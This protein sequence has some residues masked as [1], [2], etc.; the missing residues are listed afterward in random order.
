M[1]HKPNRAESN[2]LHFSLAH[3]EVIAVRLAIQAGSLQLRAEG[4]P[5]THGPEA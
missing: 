3:R 4:G 1:A 5:R 2:T